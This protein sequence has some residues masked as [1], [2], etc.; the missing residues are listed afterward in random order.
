MTKS[1]GVMVMIAVLAL[2]GC[3]AM[4]RDRY[5]KWA[6]PVWGAALGGAGAGMG[7]SKG[8]SDPSDAEIAGA[9][10]GGAVAGGLLGWLAGHYI[11]EEEQPVPPAPPSPPPPPPPGKKI[12]TLAGPSFEFDKATLTSEGRVHVDPAVKV[13][14]AQPGLQVVVAENTDSIAPT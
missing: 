13:L 9:A 1:L 3:A 14:P 8:V 7:V 10:A 6:L 11:C 2:G 12:E 4:R 5:C